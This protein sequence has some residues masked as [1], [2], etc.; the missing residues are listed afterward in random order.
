[1]PNHVGVTHISFSDEEPA[2]WQMVVFTHDDTAL[3]RAYA[4]IYRPK[5]NDLGALYVLIN[6]VNYQF[7]L[8]AMLDFSE[9]T[10]TVRV[11]SNFRGVG[12]GLPT[13]EFLDWF[14]LNLARGDFLRKVF[15]AVDYSA[16]D[17]Q[18]EYHRAV[19][20]VR[21]DMGINFTPVLS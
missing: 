15:H 1:M 16:A 9:S 19:E 20:K 7:M 17:L 5:K 6:F 8:D 12:R 13:Y 10:N 11:R 14:Q 18:A 4:H 2:P 21:I 3:A